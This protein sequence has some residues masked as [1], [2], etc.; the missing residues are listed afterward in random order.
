M[1]VAGEVIKKEHMG[2]MIVD[3]TWDLLK[4]GGVR[5]FGIHLVFGEMLAWAW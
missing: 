1:G 2:V 4:L 3:L 5:G